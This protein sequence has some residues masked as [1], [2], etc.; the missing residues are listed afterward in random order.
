MWAA[1]VNAGED[2]TK[3]VSYSEDGGATWKNTLLGE[4]VHNISFKDSLVYVAAD[5]GLFRSSDYGESWIRSGSVY[6]PSSLQR[7]MSSE[8]YGVAAQGDTVWY[9]G[10]EGIAYTIDSPSIPFGSAWRVFRTAEQVGTENRTYAFPN[11]FA[12]DDEPVRIH[13]SL[14]VNRSGISNV[15]IRLFNFAMQPVRTLI[16]QAPRLNGREYDEIW[17]G[18][19]DNRSLLANGVYF[20]RVETN[21]QDAVWGKILVIR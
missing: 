21:N 5:A 3:G 13:Y 16:Q 11:P 1:T 10:P 17:D 19:D 8:C 12:P 15:S 4:W 6:D 9:G 20:Y 14:G 7:F 18:T 2:E